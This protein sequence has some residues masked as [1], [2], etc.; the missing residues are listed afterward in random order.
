MGF[1]WVLPG[2]FSS[3]CL[4]PQGG[5]NRPGGPQISGPTQHRVYRAGESFP[6]A[7]LYV[8]RACHVTPRRSVPSR[9]LHGGHTRIDFVCFRTRPG[10]RSIPCLD[11]YLC[12]LTHACVSAAK[13]WTGGGGFGASPRIKNSRFRAEKKRAGNGIMG[14]KKWSTLRDIPRSAEAA[15]NECVSTKNAGCYCDPTGEV[16]TQKRKDK[17]FKN[18]MGHRWWWDDHAPRVNNQVK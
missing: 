11:N 1:T 13:R 4:A 14:S 10:T 3:R 6:K 16:N 8:R 5:R 17:E 2:G 15:K 18:E 7:V 9:L 12:P